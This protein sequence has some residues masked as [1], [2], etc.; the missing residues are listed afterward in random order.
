MDAQ[1]RRLEPLLPPEKPWTGRPN[2]DHRRIL[3]MT[4]HRCYQPQ[5]KR[6]A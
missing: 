4:Q 2:E 3:G 6:D 1:W 5:S